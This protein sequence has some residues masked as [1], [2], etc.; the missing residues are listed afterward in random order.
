MW[1][2]VLPLAA[3]YKVERM[4]SHSTL[5]PPLSLLAAS[6]RVQL[7]PTE[8][9]DSRTILPILMSEAPKILNDN[10]SF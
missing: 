7:L 10:H 6:R 1:G 5:L 9:G 3:S 8:G 2:R 4:C